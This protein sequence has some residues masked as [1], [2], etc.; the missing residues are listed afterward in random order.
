MHLVREL[1]LCRPVY[2]R[3]MYPFERYIKTLK[4]CMRNYN[5]LEACIVE[6]YI[7][8][9]AIEFCSEYIEGAETIGIPKPRQNP[10]DVSKGIS[11][12][13]I[14]KSKTNTWNKRIELY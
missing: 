5:R 3:W 11:S 1:K 10:K 14:E 13:P 4:G 12:G 8:E 2:L 6:S 9:E 7:T